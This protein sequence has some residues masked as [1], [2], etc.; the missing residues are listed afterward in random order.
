MTDD[1]PSTNDKQYGSCIL[2]NNLKPDLKE[3]STVRLKFCL[4]IITNS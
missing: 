3:H 2:Q 1:G 4:K